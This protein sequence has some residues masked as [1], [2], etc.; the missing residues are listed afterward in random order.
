M[1][2]YNLS[3]FQVDN[4]LL[5]SHD[6]RTIEI[7]AEASISIFERSV[8]VKKKR[9]WESKIKMN[10]FSLNNL[11]RQRESCKIEFSSFLNIF[12]YSLNVVIEHSYFVGISTKY[13]R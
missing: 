11:D 5:D 10:D 8:I 7:V 9:N 13:G 12:F 2:H 3:L 4:V 1:T 6:S